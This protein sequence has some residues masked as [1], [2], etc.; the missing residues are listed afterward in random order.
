MPDTRPAAEAAEGEAMTADREQTR[1]DAE[2][3]LHH[4]TEPA[5]ARTRLQ[6]VAVSVARSVPALLAKLEQAERER[7]EART[8]LRRRCPHSWEALRQA[9]HDLTDVG[10]DGFD[11]TRWERAN[12]ARLRLDAALTVYEQSQGNG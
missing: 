7:D 4:W 6:E 8:A 12:A 5:F 3:L 1:R 2:W 9:R 10:K 11:S